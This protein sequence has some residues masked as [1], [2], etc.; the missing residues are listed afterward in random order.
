MTTRLLALL[1]LATA[2]L[3]PIEA[4]AREYYCGWIDSNGCERLVY[5]SNDDGISDWNGINCGDGWIPISS[6][7]S[8]GGCPGSEF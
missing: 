4:I 6:G 5:D 8:I 3:F 2:L 1:S 7:G